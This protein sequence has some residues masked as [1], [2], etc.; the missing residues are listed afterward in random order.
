MRVIVHGGAGGA[1][2]DPDRRATVLDE[3]ASAGTRAESVV[4]AVVDAV[5][6]LESAPRFNAGIGGARQSDGVVRTDAGLMT[7]ERAIGA[8]CSMPGVEHAIAVARVVL[9]DTPHVQIAGEHAVSLAEAS[10]IDTNIDLTTE[11]TREHW[12]SVAPSEESEEPRLAWVRERYG[13]GP[14]NHDHDTVGAVA[15]HEGRVAAATSTGGWWCAL[16]GRVGDVPQ[17]GSGF[18]AAPA[19]G[20]SATGA[21]EA[22]ARFGLAR[23]TVEALDHSRPD[24][25]A[26]EVVAAFG[27]ATGERAGVVALDHDGH[28]GT[29]TNAESMQTADRP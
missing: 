11:R 14:T 4:D 5:Q 18:Y 16:A 25:A 10:G 26:E 19:G 2:D 23:R 24:R 20:A 7:D 12:E 13:N 3:A 9:E 6:I 1:P 15:V 28:A 21:G 27:D 22:I 8:A 29:A 17:V